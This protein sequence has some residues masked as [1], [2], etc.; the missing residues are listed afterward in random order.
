MAKEAAAKLAMDMSAG[1]GML[2][3]GYIGGMEVAGQSLSDA[4]YHIHQLNRAKSALGLLRGLTGEQR[5]SLRRRF[6]G[7]VQLDP[8]LASYHSMS[9]AA[10]MDMQRERN[11]EAYLL[12]RRTWWQGVFDRGGEH[13]NDPLDEL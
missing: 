4:P 3:G 9:M 6:E 13:G 5:A 8:D 1:S 7:R 2:G 12:N 11:I 10:R